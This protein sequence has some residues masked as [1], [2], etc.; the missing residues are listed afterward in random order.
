MMRNKIISVFIAAC[1]LGFLIF[2][3][4]I[5]PGLESDSKVYSPIPDE[6]G[7]RVIYGTPAPDKSK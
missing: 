3:F 6:Q 1:I 4:V 5:R 2:F 7:I